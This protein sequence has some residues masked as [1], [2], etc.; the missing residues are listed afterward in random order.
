MVDKVYCMSSFLMYRTIADQNKSFA[1]GVVPQLHG[2]NFERQNVHDSFEL[3]EAL[4]N[5]VQRACIDGKAALALSGGIDSAILAKYMPAGSTVYTFKCIVPGIT[6]T[7]ESPVAARYAAECGLVHKIVEIYWEDYEKYTPNLMKQKGSPI[8]SIEV[9]IYKACLQ[10]KADGFTSLIFGESADANF[11]GLSDL[12]SKDRTI[13][14]FIQRYSFV[15]PYRALKEFEI[16]LSPILPFVHDGYVEVHDFLRHS[17]FAESTASYVNAAAVAGIVPI[18]PYAYTYMAA[19]I[20]YERIRRG[21]NKYLVREIFNRL[22][23]GFSVPPK[24]P[25]PRPV[26]EWFKDWKG[27]IRPEFWP[28]CTDDMSGD[29]KW[30]VYCLERFLNCLDAGE[31]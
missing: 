17:F 5:H 28:H 4:K 18:L 16:P 8:H 15:P 20:D 27:P 21:E 19:P 31:I 23:S 3:E 14:D 10:A 29:Q 30:L 9:Q 26:N 22:Y 13:G 12:L 24:T 6:V 25:M 1:P 11:G 7:D 2:A